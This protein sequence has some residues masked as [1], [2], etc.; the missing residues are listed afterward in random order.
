MKPK[1]LINILTDICYF[2]QLHTEPTPV[3]ERQHLDRE[4]EATSYTVA[5]FLT[6]NTLRG[7]ETKWDIVLP[8]LKG[9]MATREQMKRFIKQI[10]NYYNTEEE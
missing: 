7:H 2:A 3:W 9:P 8:A 1:R 5:C 4:L 10:V 6:Q